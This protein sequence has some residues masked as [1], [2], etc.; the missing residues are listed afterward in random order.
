MIAVI[1]PAKSL[2]FESP[3]TTSLRSDPQFLAESERVMK[4]LRRLTRPKLS[5]LMNIS[6]DL[7]TLNV[8]RNQ[9]WQVPQPEETSRQAM[10]VFAGDVYTGLE[11]RS[12][13]EADIAYASDHLRILSGL[14]GLLRPLDRIQ[15]YRL[16]MGSKL[17][18]GRANDLYTFWAT[19]PRQH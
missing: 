19:S 5:K 3:I 9:Q 8:E 1:S 12:F 7:A 4:S 13:T 2:D 14:Y 16:E 6:S 10:F 15:P 18:V 11:A 17:K